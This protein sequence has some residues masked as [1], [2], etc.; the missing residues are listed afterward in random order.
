M[1]DALYLQPSEPKQLF[2]ELSMEAERYLYIPLGHQLN[3]KKVDE[4]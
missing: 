4:K 2:K 1:T 3:G